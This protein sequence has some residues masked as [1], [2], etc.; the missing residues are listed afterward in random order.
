MQTKMKKEHTLQGNLLWN[1][2]GNIVYLACQWVVTVLVTVWGGFLDAGL[3]SIAMSVSAT[4]QTVAMFGIRNFQV[5]DMQQKYAD[6]SYMGLRL[7]TC[8]AALIG[9]LGFSLIS[10]YAATQLLAIS[11]FMLFRLAESYADVLHGIA[12]KRGRLDIAGK[13][14]T[15]RGIGLLICFILGYRISGA[16]NVGLFC[17][18]ALSVGLVLAFD[19]PQVR[20]VARFRLWDSPKNCG[21]LALETLPLC[22]YLFLYSALSTVP[23][24]IL[25]RQCGEEILGAYSSIFAPA[26]LLQAATGYLYNPFATQFAELLQKKDKQSFGK[27]LG[28]ILLA[29]LAIAALVMVAAQFLGDFALTLIFGEKIRSYTF[30]LDPIL[31]VNFLLSFLGFFCMLTVVLRAFRWLLAGCGA[32]FLGCF[33]LTKPLIL[34]VG[35]ANGASYALILA[36][37]VG[38]AVLVVG[39]A[40]TLRGRWRHD[41]EMQDPT[42]ERKPNMEQRSDH[43]FAVCAYGESPYLEECI[44]SLLSQT[45]K[46]KIL[47]STSTPNALIKRVAETYGLPLYI[48]EGEKGITGDWNFAI[49]QTDTRFVTIAHQDDLYEPTYLE[50]V[51]KRADA[52]KSPILIFTEYY[53]LRNGERVDNNRLLKIKK[54]MNMGYRPFPRSRWMR[55]RMLSIGNSICCPSVTYCMDAYGDFRF[56]GNFR[57]ACDWD[58]WDRL[59]RKKGAFLYIP[60]RLMAHRI[61]EESE[62]TKQTAG[63]RRAEEEYS[64]FRRYWPK[65]I[66]RRL[67]GFYAK[68]AESNQ[69]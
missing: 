22:V 41:G 69:L 28:K 61:H 63:S 55:L 36:C 52:E 62:T 10:R 5:S 56:D 16:L 39:D 66:A 20:G 42:E 25:E 45:V 11:L 35:D 31:L 57:F 29:M 15:L 49:S 3:L 46:S 38:V 64:M 40:I 32:A 7:L 12:Q 1:A 2:V 67:S 44:R 37:L 47:I 14:F 51:L 8:T 24:L 60:K 9:C 33:L 48:N 65:W 53:E 50:E 18:T 58:A 4:C 23:K 54:L 68:G 34:Q 13:S 30:F 17:M 21:R 59:A 6:S 27:L 26:M 43:T 19:L